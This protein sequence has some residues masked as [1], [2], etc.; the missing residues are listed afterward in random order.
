MKTWIFVC[1]KCLKEI[2]T[3]FKDTYQYGGTWKRKKK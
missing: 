3:S 1:G 2:K